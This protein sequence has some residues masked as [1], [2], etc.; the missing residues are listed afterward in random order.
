MTIPS[1]RGGDGCPGRQ[2]RS[3]FGAQR[4]V[5]CP[6]ATCV[7]RRSLTWHPCATACWRWHIRRGS[8]ELS[9]SFA[10]IDL[11]PYG[12]QE[13][14]QDSPEGWPQSPTYSRWSGS[15]AIAAA[16]GPDT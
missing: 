11:L 4:R 13:E 8:K 10:L 3:Q 2:R 14:W 7:P 12:R 16:Y 9:H 1:I 15:E 5:R 6:T